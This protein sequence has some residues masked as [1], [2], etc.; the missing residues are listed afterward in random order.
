MSHSKII[1]LIFDTYT[2]TNNIYY[3][4]LTIFDVLII[5]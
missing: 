5:F 1:N 4:T 2:F 3:A